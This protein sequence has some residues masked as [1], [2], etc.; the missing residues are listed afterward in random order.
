LC[1]LCVERIVV[2]MTLGI[3]WLTHPAWRCVWGRILDVPNPCT[4]DS[5]GVFFPCSF[6]RRLSE[7]DSLGTTAVRTDTMWAEMSREFCLPPLPLD[8]GTS[9]TP[10]WPA[11]LAPCSKNQGWVTAPASPNR[12]LAELAN[13][14]RADGFSAL[15]GC[16]IR[17]WRV[18][19]GTAVYTTQ[20]PCAVPICSQF[21]RRLRCVS[22]FPC[23]IWNTE[24]CRAF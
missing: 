21:T 12:R 15:T 3:P 16:R 8:M 14:S 23:V 18:Q 1:A 2:L 10:P 17:A 22:F 13:K 5:P 20:L 19:H 11:G 4:Q 9:S 6:M 7:G 24:T